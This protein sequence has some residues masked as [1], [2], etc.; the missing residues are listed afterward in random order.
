MIGRCLQRRAVLGCRLRLE[1]VSCLPVVD[2]ERCRLGRDTLRQSSRRTGCGR[3][4]RW[5][6][7]MIKYDNFVVNDITPIYCNQ[8]IECKSS[9][10]TDASGCRC[11][12]RR[13]RKAGS[14]MRALSVVG[15]ACEGRQ[16]MA[17]GSMSIIIVLIIAVIIGRPEEDVSIVIVTI[18]V[19]VCRRSR[20]RCRC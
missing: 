6:L 19:V 18:V 3:R 20:G 15:A 5:C 9:R 8:T 16:R 2:D 13:Q 1:I 17:R 7:M 14:K 4:G 12:R 10:E 11:K